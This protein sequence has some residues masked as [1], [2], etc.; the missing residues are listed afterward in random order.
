M[1]RS[2][3][4]DVDQRSEKVFEQKKELVERPQGGHELAHP[5]CRERSVHQ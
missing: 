4:I 5:Q 3:E 2:W 1:E